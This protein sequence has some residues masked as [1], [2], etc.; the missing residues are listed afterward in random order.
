[1]IVGFTGTRYGLDLQQRTM[2]ANLLLAFM[3]GENANA[4]QLH[5]GDCIGADAEAHKL[6]REHLFHVVIHPPTDNKSR[7]YC[8]DYAAI[9]APMHYLDRNEEIVKECD[10]LIAAPFQNKEVIRS[11]TWATIRKAA[12]LGKP[13]I[14]LPRLRD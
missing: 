4:H 6:S 7:A 3:R 13:T 14:I 10:M 5:H 11:G 12:L 2:M 8:K 1:M 9:R